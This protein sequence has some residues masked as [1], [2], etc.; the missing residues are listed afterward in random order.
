M[1]GGDD[2]Q[3]HET[4]EVARQA[5]AALAAF[6]AAVGADNHRIHWKEAEGAAAKNNGRGSRNQYIMAKILPPSFQL[7]EA[8]S[9]DQN[10]GG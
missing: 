5:V 10:T 4:G 2:E 3:R 8:A 1:T 6:N 7:A 9:A